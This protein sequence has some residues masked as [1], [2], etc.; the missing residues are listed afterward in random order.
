MNI[1]NNHT[2]NDDNNNTYNNCGNNNFIMK[3]YIIIITFPQ[4]LLLL[5]IICTY[6]YNLVH[7][8]S[9]VYMYGLFSH[10]HLGPQAVLR[11]SMQTL[12]FLAYRDQGS[13][14]VSVLF[15]VSDDFTNTCTSINVLLLLTV[16]A[17]RC[18]SMVQSCNINMS[19]WENLNKTYMY[20]LT[21]LSVDVNDPSINVVFW[22]QGE[23]IRGLSG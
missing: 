11:H 5:F 16:L 9:F 13:K 21:Q 1:N 7:L 2:I 20:I 19:C 17:S 18:S 10:C 8:H 3:N 15:L 6:L 4:C 14:T 12:V 23:Y 22:H